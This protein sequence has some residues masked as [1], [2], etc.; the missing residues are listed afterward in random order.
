MSVRSKIGLAWVLGFAIISLVGC[1]D[2]TGPN[3]PGQLTVTLS[4][5]A[6]P[7]SAFLVSVVGEDVTRPVAAVGGQAVYSS[8]EGNVAKVAVVG[9]VG[10]GPLFKF[11][12]PDVSRVES[13]SVRLQQVAG[14]DN[15]LLFTGDFS[16]EITR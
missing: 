15:R 3:G 14:S 4:S 16:L 5:T 6:G 8:V 12:V 7:G 10:S 13:Y 11:S 9:T 1:G 2:S